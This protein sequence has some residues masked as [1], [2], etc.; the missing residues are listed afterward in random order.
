MMLCVC[1]VVFD[2]HDPE[3]SL[4]HRRHIYAAK[5]EQKR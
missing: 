4:P 3:R 5:A 1:G 2:S